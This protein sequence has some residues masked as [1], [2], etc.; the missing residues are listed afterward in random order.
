M[1]TYLASTLITVLVIAVNNFDTELLRFA[2]ISR[3][4]PQSSFDEITK[5]YVQIFGITEIVI[6]SSSVIFYVL[7]RFFI[8]I[9]GFD[10]QTSGIKKIGP[11]KSLIQR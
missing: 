6:K 7:V 3:I 5:N 4:T 2:I 9:H 8:W 1:V 11:K 10:L